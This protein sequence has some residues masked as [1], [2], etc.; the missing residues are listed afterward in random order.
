MV[1]QR[2]ER[3]YFPEVVAVPT[4]GKIATENTIDESED[5]EMNFERLYYGGRVELQEKKD[6]PRWQK[7]NWKSWQKKQE[8]VVK[9]RG[10]REAQLN[11]MAGV[12]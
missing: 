4:A 9:R 2:R 1:E 6:M 5:L 12:E 7:H 10:Q 8:K 11:R 3:Y